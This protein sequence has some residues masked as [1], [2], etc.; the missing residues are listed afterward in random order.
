LIEERIGATRNQISNKCKVLEVSIARIK[1]AENELLPLPPHPLREAERSGRSPHGEATRV[2][3]IA[4]GAIPATQQ[5][6]GSP[7]PSD[8]AASKTKAL[9]ARLSTAPDA[10]ER[11][12]ILRQ[13]TAAPP[14]DRQAAI[15]ALVAALDDLAPV[16]RQC[17]IDCL[18]SFGPD[19]EP[20]VPALVK[21][22]H[23]D[24]TRSNRQLILGLLGDVNGD[25]TEGLNLLIEVARG[26]SSGKARMLSKRY[27]ISERT[28]AIVALGRLGPKAGKA[29][30]VLLDILKLSAADIEQF[31]ESFRVSAEALGNIGVSGRGVSTTLKHFRDGKGIRPPH[32]GQIEQAKLNADTALKK[33]ELTRGSQPEC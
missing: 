26:A 5:P 1:T 9:I 23:S 27:S 10:S 16:V 33:L 19:A 7:A 31:R 12:Q 8:Q 30:P 22:F 11:F 6:S 25:S 13:L 14:A 28:T 24:A 18:R 20:A 17:A 21:H 32:S 2:D 4:G 29:V 15:G 3:Q